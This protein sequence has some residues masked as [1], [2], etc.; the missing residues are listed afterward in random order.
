MV[1]VITEA[2]NETFLRDALVQ[3]YDLCQLNKTRIRF[4]IS[5]KKCTKSTAP[6]W[7]D[8]LKTEISTE[9]SDLK[10][11]TSSEVGL[12]GVK[13]F[14]KLD[15]A[16]G[17][18]R[19]EI[20][21]VQEWMNC[22]HGDWICPID[23]APLVWS[24]LLL[25]RDKIAPN[26]R[27]QLKADYEEGLADFTE[28]ID[29]FLSVNA[30]QLDASKIESVKDRLLREFPSLTDLEDYLQVII[31]RPVIIPALSEQLSRKE[32]ECLEQ[33]SRFI[34]EYDSNLEQRL[35]ESAI[36]GGEQLAAQLLEDLAS[37]EP[38][39]KPVQFKKKMERHLLTLS[40]LKPLRFC[41]QSKLRQYP[42]PNSRYG[43][44]RPSTQ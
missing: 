30:W 5:L 24:Q 27:E 9:E 3:R 16:A 8:I 12:R 26:L 36:A 18:L 1:Q 32:A 39:H 42:K 11:I 20:A 13:V 21:S 6:K 31:A 10:K 28:R 4:R 17:K 44:Q 22:D 34:Q 37:W 33:I 19:Q 14:K 43:C 7:A 25:I 15:E 29:K 2:G 23:L 38:G 41:G 35:K 40:G